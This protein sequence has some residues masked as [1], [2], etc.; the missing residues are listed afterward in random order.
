MGLRIDMMLEPGRGL[1]VEPDVLGNLPVD[2]LLELQQWFGVGSFI[3]RNNFSCPIVVEED[4]MMMNDLKESR[5]IKT[6]PM[7]PMISFFKY[8]SLEDKDKFLQLVEI[9]LSN[10]KEAM[11]MATEMIMDNDR[12]AYSKKK[13]TEQQKKMKVPQNNAWRN[14]LIERANLVDDADPVV[15]FGDGGESF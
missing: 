4:I 11:E 15:V 6:F 8:A 2:V 7:I 5:N 3:C 13:K 12:G 1:L 10:N 14:E 9:S